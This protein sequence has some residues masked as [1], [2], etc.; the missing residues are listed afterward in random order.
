MW[1]LE[2]EEYFKAANQNSPPSCDEA[3][4]KGMKAY[5]DMDLKEFMVPEGQFYVLGDC[6]PR[7]IDSQV[8]G[9]IEL[10][11][12]KGRVLGYEKI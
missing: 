6:W 2:E 5:F 7:S 12:V 11:N 4:Q 1:G 8:F 3:C 9:S 10:G